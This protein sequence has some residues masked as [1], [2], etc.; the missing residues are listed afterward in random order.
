MEL[1]IYFDYT[2][3]WFT[4]INNHLPPASVFAEHRDGK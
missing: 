4:D 2:L 1:K 3:H